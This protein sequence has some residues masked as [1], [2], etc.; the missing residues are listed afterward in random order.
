M[1]ETTITSSGHFHNSKSKKL[2]WAK[3]V[4]GYLRLIKTECKLEFGCQSVSN[5]NE[6]CI[7]GLNW[8]VDTC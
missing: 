3:L 1:K 4:I 5:D 2:V 6:N 7:D 8:T